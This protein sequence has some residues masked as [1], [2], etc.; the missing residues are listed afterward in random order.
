MKYRLLG[1]ALMLTG[2]L[3]GIFMEDGSLVVFAL[4]VGL[5]LAINGYEEQDV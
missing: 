2:I 1:L 4:P 3:S 5:Y